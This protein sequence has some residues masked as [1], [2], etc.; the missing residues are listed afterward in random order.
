M[1]NLHAGGNR[2]EVPGWGDDQQFCGKP[3]Q[4]PRRYQ[5]KKAIMRPQPG[6]G[7]L[8]GEAP[9]K[10]RN[11]H[12]TDLIAARAAAQ[13]PGFAENWVVVA[14]SPKCQFAVTTS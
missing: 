5:R 6:V 12:Q 13:G 4:V 11:K 14:M 1:P 8:P 9:G 2:G 7:L 10:R 3:N